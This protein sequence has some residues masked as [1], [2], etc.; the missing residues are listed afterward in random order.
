MLNYLERNESFDNIAE[1]CF[2]VDE[3]SIHSRWGGIEATD[4]KMLVKQPYNKYLS[5]VNGYCAHRTA[6]IE[7]NRYISNS[8]IA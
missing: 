8:Y 3:Q 2:T 7:N 4:K 6:I 1:A 5:V